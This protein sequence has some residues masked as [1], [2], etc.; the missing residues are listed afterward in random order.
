MQLL[1]CGTPD[2]G[3]AALVAIPELLEETKEIT[4][5]DRFQCPGNSVIFRYT[6]EAIQKNTAA[7]E[8]ADPGHKSWTK[9][10]VRFASQT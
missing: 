2:I 4:K 1:E 5:E 7:P 3:Q 8:L 10:H 6:I 9:S